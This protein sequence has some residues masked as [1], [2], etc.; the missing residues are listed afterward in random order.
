[1]GLS[2]Q[3]LLRYADE[4]GDVLNRIVTGDETRVHH[5]QPKSKRFNAMETSQFTFKQ[6]VYGY[7]ISKEDYAYR[8]LGFSGSTLS[9]FSEAWWKREFCIVL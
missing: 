1:M 5:Y 9:P 4:G 6:K 2:L 7:T 8:V 3:H